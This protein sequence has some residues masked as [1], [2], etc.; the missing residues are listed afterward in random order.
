MWNSVP[1]SI[2]FDAY[3]LGP[4]SSRRAR[5]TRL[6]AKLAVTLDLWVARSRQRRQLGDLAILN[7]HLLKDIGVAQDEASREAAKWFWQK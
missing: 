1:G 2:P 3:G 5:V 7:T 4:R 6:A